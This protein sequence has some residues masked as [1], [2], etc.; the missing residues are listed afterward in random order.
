MPDRLAS[1]PMYHVNR[2]DLED[3]VMGEHF[4]T[5]TLRVPEWAAERMRDGQIKHPWIHR[6]GS[7]PDAD[8]APPADW[9]SACQCTLHENDRLAKYSHSAASVRPHEVNPHAE[10]FSVNR[11]DFPL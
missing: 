1:N 5:V 7:L 6:I 4:V 3:E 11:D 10:D 2:T 8:E 9:P